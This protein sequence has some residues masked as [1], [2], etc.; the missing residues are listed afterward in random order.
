MNSVFNSLR[1]NADKKH[2][3]IYFRTAITGYIR[4]DRTKFERAC[5]NLVSNAIDFAKSEV[6]IEIEESGIDLIF[7]VADDGLGVPDEFLPRLFQRG[8]T[9]GKDDGTGLG[10]AYVR[11][12]MRGHG[13]DVTYRRENG[14]TIFECRLPNAVVEQEDKPLEIAASL[15]LKLEQKQVKKVAICLDPQS[16]SERVLSELASQKSEVFLFSGERAGAQI[17]V[18]NIDDIMFEVLEKDDQQFIQIS[19]SWGNEVQMIILLKRKFNLC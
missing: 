10:L 12:I 13:G 14:F 16:L 4:V 7:R 19:E 6:R 1:H 3:H 9:H 18:S 15:E 17:V 8:A 2:V 5:L 11:Q